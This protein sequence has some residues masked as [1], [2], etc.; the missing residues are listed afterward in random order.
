[1]LTTHYRF[2]DQ[3]YYHFVW[4]S[5]ERIVNTIIDHRWKFKTKNSIEQYHLL[6]ELE[7]KDK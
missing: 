5:I 1:M 3:S 4:Y 6:H 7:M 2:K